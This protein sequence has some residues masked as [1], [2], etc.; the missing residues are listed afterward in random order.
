MNYLT[1]APEIGE[2]MRN[3]RKRAGLTQAEVAEKMNL[4]INYVSD[5]ENGKK[6]MSLITIASLCQCYQLSADYFL[7]GIEKSEKELTLEEILTYISTLSTP[8]L[9]HLNSYVSSLLSLREEEK[10]E[11]RKMTT[12]RTA[13]NA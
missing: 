12:K 13:K 2:R 9:D 4:S 1:S 11:S 5:L 7:F 10:T 6:N 3:A 8:T